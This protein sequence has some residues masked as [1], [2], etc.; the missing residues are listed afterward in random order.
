MNSLKKKIP[1]V[2]KPRFILLMVPRVKEMSI[3]WNQRSPGW[4]RRG[5]KG[6]GMLLVFD[7][8]C[9]TWRLN[10]P[11]GGRQA[12][13]GSQQSATAQ[14]TVPWGP[15]T[16]AGSGSGTTLQAGAARAQGHFP[17]SVLRSLWYFLSF[18][19]HR[20]CMEATS[21]LASKWS[22]LADK[23]ISGFALGLPESVAGLK[24][25]KY[26]SF[27][28]FPSLTN[29]HLWPKHIISSFLSSR[30]EFLARS[31]MSV[32]KGGEKLWHESWNLQPKENIQSPTV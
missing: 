12:G 32:R 31:S 20:A 14:A 6:C 17:R 7:C 13:T 22:M 15:S 5:R 24:K 27:L 21:L 8:G 16:A 25:G 3:K 29:I 10:V 23:V 26:Y 30:T 18:Q 4:R 9:G 28:V 19:S 1:T 2:T 11:D